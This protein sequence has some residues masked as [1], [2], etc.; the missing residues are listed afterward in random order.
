ML[1]DA[2]VRI[3][4][5]TSVNGRP[6]NFPFFPRFVSPVYVSRLPPSSSFA[7]DVSNRGRSKGRPVP[8]KRVALRFSVDIRRRI[9]CRTRQ[10]VRLFPL[11]YLPST[12]PG[13]SARQDYTLA[14]P[15]LIKYTYC[16]ARDGA[17]SIPD[18]GQWDYWEELISS[19]SALPII[20]MG[21]SCLALNWIA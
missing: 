5:D 7:L 9:N 2:A 12:P 8:L 11:V 1:F 4:S 14:R 3:T 19:I 21:R 6:I 15:F 13:A 10:T 17:A 18:G 16:A 20:L